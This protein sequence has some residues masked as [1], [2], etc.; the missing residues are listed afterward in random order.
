[1]DELE[2]I[3]TLEERHT[4]CKN[5][6]ETW[7]GQHDKSADEFRKFVKDVVSETSD[8]ITLLES[9]M[10]SRMTALEGKMENNVKELK[11]IYDPIADTVKKWQGQM[12]VYVGIYAIMASIV[13]QIIVNVVTRKGG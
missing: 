2:R 11:K 9:K 3:I 10:E 5:A 13:A 1:M 8:K 12:I 6:K 4:A 7:E